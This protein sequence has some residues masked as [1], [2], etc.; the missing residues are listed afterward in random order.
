MAK[1][2]IIS[3]DVM[4]AND[5]GD[6]FDF[7]NVTIRDK[8]DLD[9][10][11]SNSRVEWMLAEIFNKGNRLLMLKKIARPNPQHK[12]NIYGP[13]KQLHE[14]DREIAELEEKLAKKKLLRANIADESTHI[15]HVNL[16]G[17]AKDWLIFN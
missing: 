2:K 16:Q 1:N 13:Y 6:V 10:C 11:Y 4:F 7:T 17:E 9:S 14:L 5:K 3:L 8:Y 15:K 12:D